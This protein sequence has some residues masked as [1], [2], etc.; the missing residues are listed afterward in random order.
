M[1]NLRGSVGII[2]AM[3]TFQKAKSLVTGEIRMLKSVVLLSL[4]H[5]R[6]LLKIGTGLLNATSSIL[7]GNLLQHKKKIKKS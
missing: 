6:P 5:K 2:L 7:T 3:S 1:A 4:R